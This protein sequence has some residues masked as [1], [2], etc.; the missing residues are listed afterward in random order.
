MTVKRYYY[1]LR[2][3]GPGCQP[4]AGLVAVT[5]FG[6]CR[7][8]ESVGCKAWGVCEYDRE[9]S[10]EEIEAFELVPVPD[11]DSPYLGR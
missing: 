3:P 10:N 8:I 2:P 4:K 5:A 1:R 9:L 6:T 7:Y 11:N